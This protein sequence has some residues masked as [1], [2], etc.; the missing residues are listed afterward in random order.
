VVFS[1]S[2][3]AVTTGRTALETRLELDRLRELKRGATRD[4]GIGGPNLAA[5]AVRA[6]LVD[7]YRLFIVP[8]V[9][10]GG[11]PFLPHGARLDV[12]LAHQ[13]RF[14][15]GVMFLEYHSR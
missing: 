11:I 7:V 15:D 9:V 13:H 10:G 8:V 6:G 3:D 5:E 12:A 4:I 2:L 14:G 1:S